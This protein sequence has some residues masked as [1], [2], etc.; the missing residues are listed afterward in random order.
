MSKAK[1]DVKS[2]RNY[3]YYGIVGYFRFIA[4][5]KTR[6]ED[7][8]W[9]KLNNTEEN[10]WWMKVGHRKW[11]DNEPCVEN[12]LLSIMWMGVNA[13]NT[14]WAWRRLPR[15]FRSGYWSANG[16]SRIGTLYS[17]CLTPNEKRTPR[18][19]CWVTSTFI[20]SSWLSL[21]YEW[22]D[23]SLETGFRPCRH[24]HERKI[25]HLWPSCIWVIMLS[26]NYL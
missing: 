13:F 3:W 11:L 14:V 18:S 9:N 20:S 6:T 17:E 24:T 21:H 5:S 25:K 7:W 10:R 2:E 8:K 16:S 22:F 15:K 1:N 23:F 12:V 19:T 26:H 4:I